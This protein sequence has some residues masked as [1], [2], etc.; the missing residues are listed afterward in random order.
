[1][2]ILRNP[3]C[4]HAIKTGLFMAGYHWGMCRKTYFGRSLVCSLARQSI[5]R[6][7]NLFFL[8]IIGIMLNIKN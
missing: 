5:V 7:S 1:M 6:K 4:R 8:F 3:P 2:S